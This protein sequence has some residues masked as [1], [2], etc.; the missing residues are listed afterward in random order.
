MISTA[1]T[2]VIA[3]AAA[4]IAAAVTTVVVLVNINYFVSDASSSG[5]RAHGFSAEYIGWYE[6]GYQRGLLLG[7]IDDQQERNLTCEAA[8]NVPAI[9]VKGPS[10]RNSGLRAG[11]NDASS[12]EPRL[13]FVPPTLPEG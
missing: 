1:R 4:V 13:N 5:K 10:D 2:T 12:G 11:C 7:Q 3:V 6:I 9:D 8:L